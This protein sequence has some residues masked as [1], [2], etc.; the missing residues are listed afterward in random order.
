MSYNKLL[1]YLSEK[2]SGTWPELKAAWEWIAGPSEDPGDQAWVVARDL[3]SLGHIEIT[4]GD[5]GGWCAAPVVVTMV[6]RSGGRALVTGARTRFF[7]TPADDGESGIGRLMD[8]AEERDLWVDQ[9][10]AD[11]GPVTLFVACESDSDAR[12]LAGAL[13]VAYTYEV[14]EQLAALLPPL[15]SYSRLWP[16]GELPRGLDAEQFDTEPLA[17]RTADTTQEYGLY[18]CRTYQGHVYALKTVNGWR[19]VNRELG[20]FEVLR[21]EEKSVLAYSGERFQLSMPVQTPLPTLH[22]RS[23]TLCSGRLP[24]FNYQEGGRLTYDNIP[25]DVASGVASALSQGLEQA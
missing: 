6:P 24:R 7:Y 21:W 16:E 12:D 15:A 19:R 22:A 9:C 11:G 13:G 17:W 23:A 5:D 18:R 2:G 4:W 3:A 14:A 1:A 8:V 20:V 10:E 25:E